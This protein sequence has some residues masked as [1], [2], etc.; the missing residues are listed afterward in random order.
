MPVSAISAAQCRAGRALAGLTPTQLAEK[1]RLAIKT[2]ADFEGN[3]PV[4][5]PG[6]MIAIIAVLDNLGVDFI[7]EDETGGAGVRLKRK[8]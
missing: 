2:L 7:A 1:A 3:G 8:K 5:G 6:N 4:P